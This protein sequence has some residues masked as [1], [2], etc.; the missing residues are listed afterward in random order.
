MPSNILQW[1]ERIVEGAMWRSRY[2]VWVGVVT[3]LVAM[4]GVFWVTTVDAFNML[5][6]VALYSSV[7]AA[8]RDKVRAEILGMVIGVVDGYLMATFLLIFGLGLYELF[9]SKIEEAEADDMAPGVLTI[10]SLDDLKTRLGR[11]VL[12]MLIVNFFEHA[13]GMDMKTM[14]DL[15]IFACGI[16]LISFALFLTHFGGHG[17]AP[18]K[19]GGKEHGEPDPNATSTDGEG[20]GHGQPLAHAGAAAPAAATMT[21]VAAP[22]PPSKGQQGKKRR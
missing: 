5:D 10:H 15:L 21:T 9:I 20:N 6:D 4:L 11:V 18:E 2:V 14:M 22:A 19:K 17:H 3:S 12:M 13:V 7:D 1:S 8:S 16:V